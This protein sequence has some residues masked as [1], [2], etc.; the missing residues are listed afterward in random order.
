MARLPIRGTPNL[1]VLVGT[2]KEL[3]INPAWFERGPDSL[4]LTAPLEVSGIAVEGLSLRGRARKS[5]ADREVIFQL[6]YHTADV[7]GGPICRIEWRPLNMH[8]NKNIGPK[9][10]RNII[11]DGSHHH[12]FDLNW[13]RSEAAVLRGELP[14]AVPLNNEPANFRALLAIVGEEFRIRRI[15]SIPVPPW[16]PSML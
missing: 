6:E 11:L 14:I 4:E 8:N 10:F 13:Q 5:L 15:Q 9:E 16:E 7:V 12:R 2:E 1:P 3:A